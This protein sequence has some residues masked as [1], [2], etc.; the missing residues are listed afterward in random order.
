MEFYRQRIIHS[1]WKTILP[2]SKAVQITMV[3]LPGSQQKKNR[4][5]AC[6]RL[7]P[8]ENNLKLW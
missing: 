4:L 2:H 5:G 6:R 1:I 8:I 7:D 3:E